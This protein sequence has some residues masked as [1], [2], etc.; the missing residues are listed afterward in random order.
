MKKIKILAFVAVVI[1]GVV[2]S[3]AL[4]Q[5]SQL[6]IQANEI[7]LREQD[8]D[9]KAAVRE[10]QRLSNLVVH[11][12]NS[13]PV[14]YTAEL[15]KLRREA[16]ALKKQSESLGSQL[17][18]NHDTQPAAPPES[19]P[20]EYWEQLHQMAGA[21]PTDARDLAS[22]L[23]RY[24]SD[25]EGQ[26]PTNLDQIVVYLGK[27]KLVLSGTN[28]FEIVYQGSL[29]RLQGI[30]LGT[31][32]V[33]RDEQTWKGPDGKIMRV[34]GMADGVGQMVASDDNFQSWE[35]KHIIPP[36]HASQPGQ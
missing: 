30:P 24:A 3:L 28:Q 21:K 1:A 14:D 5:K 16:E 29:E 12:D 35:A 34:Y 6:K 18:K 9:L 27:E 15:S 7:L 32:A 31:V 4:H 10:N 26:F 8:A 19:H 17:Q 20:P 33:I 2:T 11:A 36:P 25:H 23:Q 13:G 22:A